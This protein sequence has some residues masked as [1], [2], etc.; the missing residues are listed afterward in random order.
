MLGS[1]LFV[2]L[3]CGL[4]CWEKTSVQAMQVKFC[5]VCF[6]SYRW[7]VQC[8]H[9]GYGVHSS[10]RIIVMWLPLYAHSLVGLIDGC[11]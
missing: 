7:G 4:Q 11:F 10:S 5:S 9:C 1:C 6:P 2:A 8:T 3:A